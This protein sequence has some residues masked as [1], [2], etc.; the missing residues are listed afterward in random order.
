[1]PYVPFIEE[2]LT[3]VRCVAYRRQNFNKNRPQG[4]GLD[5][6]SNGLS[7]H[8]KGALGEW[9]VAKYYGDY[10]LWRHYSEDI[11]G[12]RIGDVG[13]YEVRATDHVDGSL[14]LRIKDDEHKPAHTPFICVNDLSV[15]GCRIAGWLNLSDGIKS[16]WWRPEVRD[17]CWMVPFEELHLISELPK[18]G[19][20]P[21]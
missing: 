11:S 14:V 7:E 13:E 21:Q 2:G 3:I 12:H 15:R 4:A 19:N 18:Q 10:D 1:M 5:G 16:K 9:A 17:P 8:M 6:V 20:L